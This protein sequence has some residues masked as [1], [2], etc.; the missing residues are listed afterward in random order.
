MLCAVRFPLEGERAKVASVLDGTDGFERNEEGE[1]RLSSRRAAFSRSSLSISGSS[2]MRAV[3][4]S[5]VGEHL[6]RR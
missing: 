6:F 1:P 5:C 4:C 3:P 2:R